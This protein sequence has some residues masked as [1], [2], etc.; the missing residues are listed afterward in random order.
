M[1]SILGWTGFENSVGQR[2]PQFDGRNTIDFIVLNPED[3][4]HLHTN[5]SQYVAIC[6]NLNSQHLRRN[7]MFLR[8]CTMPTRTD[9]KMVT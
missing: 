9:R 3:D 7:L 1:V 8:E 6:R 4:K 2:V 5:M